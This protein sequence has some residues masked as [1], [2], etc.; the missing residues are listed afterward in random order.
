MRIAVTIIKSTGHVSPLFEAAELAL[1]RDCY[2]GHIVSEEELLLPADLSEKLKVLCGA[3]VKALIC[4]AI[5]NETVALLQQ[6]GVAVYPFVVGEWHQ[7]LADWRWHR[8][9]RECHIMPGCGQ[10]HRRC[11]GRQ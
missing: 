11:C 3:G 5:A 10:H 9:V 1:V 6:R 4:G 7:V 8:Q 2:R